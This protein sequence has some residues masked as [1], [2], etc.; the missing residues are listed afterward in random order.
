MARP[1]ILNSGSWADLPLE[2]LVV[3]AGEA[4]YHG[5]ELACWGDHCEVQRALSED[6]HCQGKLNLFARQDLIVSV[7]NNQR[8]GQAVCDPIGKPHQAWLPEYV[9]GDGQAA[10]VQQRA[11]EEMVA[12]VR[13]A[14]KLGALVVCCNT[15]SPLWPFVTGGPP[16]STQQ[17]RAGLR[18]AIE[19]W[20]PVLDACQETG[21]K[22]GLILAAGQLAFDLDS[23]EA[24]LDAAGGREELGFTLDPAALHWQGVDPVEVVRQLAERIHLVHVTDAAI[25][26][27]GRAGLFNG[28]RPMGDSRRGWD[29]RCPGHGGVDWEA[30]IRALNEVGYDGPLAVEA[31]DPAMHRDHALEEA[32]RFVKRL[33]F[34]PA[35]R[36]EG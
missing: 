14:Q 10:G 13:V 28:Y 29:L 12:T 25:R 33:D 26:L 35:P 3:K 11:A 32:L 31:S 6:D 24:L 8:V 19:S 1:V 2:E 22:I 9:W 18:E 21:L 16:L 23:A 34:E 36:G 15:G 20:R 7:V 27:N 5:L 17:I 4:G 30:L